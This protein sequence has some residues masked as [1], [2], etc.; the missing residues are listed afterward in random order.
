MAINP[1]GGF[2]IIH[3]T[4]KKMNLKDELAN[5]FKLVEMGDYDFAAW[6]RKQDPNWTYQQFDQPRGTF[7][8]AHGKTIAV[9]FYN[10]QACTRKIYIKKTA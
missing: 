10:N 9:V 7:Y 5:D 2:M 6:L 3:E 1:K 4:Q 8:I